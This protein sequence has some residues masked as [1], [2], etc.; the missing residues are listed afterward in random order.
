[1]QKDALKSD[2]TTKSIRNDL[3]YAYLE[4]ALC[5]IERDI[6]YQRDRLQRAIARRQQ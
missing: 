6:V 1:M 3:L 4:Y 2:M 5:L